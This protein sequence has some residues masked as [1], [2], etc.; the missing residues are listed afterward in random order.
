M[1]GFEDPD[2]ASVSTESPTLSR[3]GRM[4]ILQT[5]SS[6]HW[7]LQSF[8]IKTA[9]LRGRSDHRQLAMEPVKE[10]RELLHMKDMKLA[11]CKEMPTV[12]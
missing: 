11:Y 5:V 9:F 4:V 7:Q 3:D 12:G 1:R 2:L 6:M 10:L 8:D